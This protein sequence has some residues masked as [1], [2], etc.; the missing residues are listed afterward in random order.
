MPR[1]HTAPLKVG[2]IGV[3]MHAQR[4]L[5]PTLALVPEM[6]LV[7]LATAHPKTALQA[8]DRYHMICHVGIEEMIADPQV[9]AVLAV[10]CPHQEAILMALDAGK[11]VWC[12]TPTINDAA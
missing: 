3:G 12:E 8:E 7:A 6:R 2:M 1:K 10:G 11:P 9:E 5:L 4:I